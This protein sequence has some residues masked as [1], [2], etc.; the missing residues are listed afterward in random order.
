MTWTSSRPQTAKRLL[1]YVSHDVS[2]L[3][4]RKNTTTTV[5]AL[6]V[7]LHGQIAQPIG[8]TPLLLS[9]FPGRPK[10]FSRQTQLD[11][12]APFTQSWHENASQSDIN[13]RENLKV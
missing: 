13:V 4:L 2:K 6:C 7:V 1:R 8:K 12:I 10:V 9:R 3:D 11:S 5:D